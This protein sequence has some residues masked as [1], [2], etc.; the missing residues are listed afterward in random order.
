MINCALNS[1]RALYTCVRV[2]HVYTRLINYRESFHRHTTSRCLSALRSSVAHTKWPYVIRRPS[3]ARSSPSLDKLHVTDYYRIIVSS[4]SNVTQ[5]E[6]FTII[7]S[8]VGGP[9][10]STSRDTSVKIRF[11]SR[12]TRKISER[13]ERIERYFST[14]IY[15]GFAQYIIINH[16]TLIILEP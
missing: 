6:V 12:R 8:R 9:S 5:G 4:W 7:Q 1:L 3:S 13:I 14:D 11:A 15:Q 2:V 10:L 16:T